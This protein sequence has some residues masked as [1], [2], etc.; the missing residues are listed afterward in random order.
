MSRK[1]PYLNVPELEQEIAKSESRIEKI[2]ELLSLEQT[3][4]DGELVKKY[5]QELQ[6]VQSTLEQ[7]YEHLEESLEL[8]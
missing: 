6:E 1:F 3:L 2:F 4:R 5:N 8:N 7:L